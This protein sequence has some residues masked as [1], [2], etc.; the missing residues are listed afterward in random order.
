MLRMAA[1]STPEN[2][3]TNYVDF[4]TN[5]P[6]QSLSTQTSQSP[7]QQDGFMPSTAPLC[8]AS[9]S[10]YRHQLHYVWTD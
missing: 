4:R 8:V 3:G 9:S 1:V 10:C 2:N 7:T 6:Q 5:N